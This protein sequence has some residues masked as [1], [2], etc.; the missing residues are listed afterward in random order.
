MFL[1]MLG[2]ITFIIWDVITECRRKRTVSLKIFNLPSPNSSSRDGKDPT[3]RMNLQTEMELIHGDLPKI[4]ELMEPNNNDLSM[5]SKSNLQDVSSNTI[6]NTVLSN[7][8]MKPFLKVH[9]EALIP[10]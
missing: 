6:L 10:N 2:I 9:P 5:L 4:T 7:N 3:N 8:T 1:I